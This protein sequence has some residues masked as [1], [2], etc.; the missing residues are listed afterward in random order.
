MARRVVDLSQPI[1][2]K[3]KSVIK[4]CSYF[5]VALNK[6]VDLTDVSQLMIFA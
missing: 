2:C 6:S 1:T 5:S 4:N 3:L